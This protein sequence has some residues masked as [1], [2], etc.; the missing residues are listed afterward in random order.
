MIFSHS[1]AFYSFLD[2]SR[3]KKKNVNSTG[4]PVSS[5]TLSW[6]TLT[7][8]QSYRLRPLINLTITRDGLEEPQLAVLLGAERLD[9]ENRK[10]KTIF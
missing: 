8:C 7:T 6:L 10:V 1:C 2:I 4:I 9:L 3:L 5:F